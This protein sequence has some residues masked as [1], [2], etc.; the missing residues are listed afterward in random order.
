M[1]VSFCVFCTRCS[2]L[3]SALYLFCNFFKWKS[4]FSPALSHHRANCIWVATRSRAAA[5]AQKHCPISTDQGEHF[6][7]FYFLVFRV[8]PFMKSKFYS[9]SFHFFLSP[10][11]FCALCC[12]VRFVCAIVCMLSTSLMFFILLSL[13][14][15]SVN[16][17]LLLLFGI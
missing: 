16:L 14:P 4:F 12:V 1:W 3:F 8:L 13:V 11:P 7:S 9:S 17:L 2:S 5:A 15:R 10:I 6:F